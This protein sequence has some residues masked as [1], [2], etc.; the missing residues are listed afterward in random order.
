MTNTRFDLWPAIN[1]PATLQVSRSIASM[2]S[3][4]NIVH[5]DQE[6]AL[7]MDL[8]SFAIDQYWDKR[9]QTDPM[10]LLDHIAAFCSKESEIWREFE[11]AGLSPLLERIR[12]TVKVLRF[13]YESYLPQLQRRFSSCFVV[14]SLSYGRFYSFRGNEHEKP[15]DLDLFLVMNEGGFGRADILQPGILEDSIDEPRRLDKFLRGLNERPTDLMNYKLFNSRDGFGVSLTICTEDGLRNIL[16]FGDGEHRSTTLHWNTC[17]HGRSVRRFDLAGR[18]YTVRY[19][20][21]ESDFGGTTLTLPVATTEI[22]KGQQLRRFNGFAEM[23]TPRFDWTF[24]S[25]KVRALILS[26]VR[27]IE[28]ISRDFVKVGLTPHICNV[29]CRHDRFSHQFRDRMASQFN[30]LN[31]LT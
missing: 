6:P 15:S 2:W 7:A 18:P 11:W 26:F 8:A 13:L 24:Q 27:Q 10:E 23:L 22:F 30:N 1:H 17:L 21:G 31:G 12:P 3:A 29:H 5:A 28:D 25:E 9:F 14:G 19:R 4:H 20:E 16:E